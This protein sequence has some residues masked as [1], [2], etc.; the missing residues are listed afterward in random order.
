VEHVRTLL[1]DLPR[2]LAVDVAADRFQSFQTYPTSTGI[3]L[4]S[5][6]TAL[7]FNT[8]HEGIHAGLLLRLKRALGV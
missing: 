2:R 4:A 3:T 5:F 6:E 8:L 7:H 1:V